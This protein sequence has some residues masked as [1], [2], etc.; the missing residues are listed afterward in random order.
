MSE[1]FIDEAVRLL[2]LIES[3]RIQKKEDFFFVESMKTRVKFKGFVS[4]KHIF[5]LRDIKDRQLEREN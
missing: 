1:N 5:W 2:D 4:R 3:K